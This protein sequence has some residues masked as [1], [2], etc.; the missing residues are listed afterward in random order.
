MVTVALY[1]QVLLD[2]ITGIY[3]ENTA[4]SKRPLILQKE[5]V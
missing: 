4:K 3:P 5:E 1:R 2:I